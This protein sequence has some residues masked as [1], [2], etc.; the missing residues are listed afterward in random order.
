MNNE[1][2]AHLW[3]PDEEAH[4]LTKDLT[5]R[6]KQ[7]NISFKEHGSKLSRN[8]QQIKTDIDKLGRNNSLADSGIIVLGVELQEGE[9]V[10][11]KDDLFAS[12]G[13]KVNAVRDTRNA[14]VSITPSQYQKLNERIDAYSNNGTYRTSF[15]NVES[16]KPYTGQV[17]DSNAIKKNVAME[18][19]PVTIDIQL[20]L[21]P[22]LDREIYQNV[23]D[24][25]TQRTEEIQGKIESVYYLSD[26]TPVIRAII[27]SV[28]LSGYEDDPAVYRIEETS[29]FTIDA[30]PNETVDLTNLILNPEININ[31]LPIV[32]ILD[33]GVSFPSNFVSLIA[34]QW[35]PKL[36]SAGGGI[37]DSIHGTKV[38]GNAVFRYL[39][40]NIN[41][42]VITP[43][44]RI[45]DCNILTGS[46]PQDIFL[47]RIREAVITFENT[48]KIFN[49]SANANGVP[50]EG[51]KMSILG[52]E[53]DALQYKYGIQFVVSA[54]NHNLWQ[55]EDSLTNIINDDDTRISSP[56]DSMLSIVVGSVVGENHKDSLSQKDEIAPYSRR[57]P[58]FI[59]FSKPDISAYAGTLIFLQG[60][61]IVPKDDYSLVLSKK[62]VLEPD[63]GTSYSAP[64]IA[65][66]IAEISSFLPNNDILL[67]KALLYQEVTPLWDIDTTN[68]DEL[69]EWHNRYGRGISNLEYSKYSSTSRVTLLR[70]GTL[71]RRTKERVSIYM[72]PVL[73]A[74]KGRNTA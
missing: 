25:L 45:I 21:I 51:D 55:F 68:D 53:L 13:M 47:Q 43:R 20:M 69:S 16:F 12:N 26:D 33:S 54:G 23:I 73:A 8:L 36:S 30:D 72:P 71:N 64:I 27:P 7:R 10:Q 37:G 62:G 40:Q 70:T 60:K 34:S 58:G 52:Y 22:N 74:Q 18:K 59:G 4:K 63:A 44:A 66:D 67:A 38:A 56:A 6:P 65:G 48:A 15:E 50:I 57:G 1:Q 9:K 24:K 31:E 11:D 17:K 5:S 3:I 35:Q 46:V 42:N 19:P 2:L 41:G 29:F 49:L 14:I 39:K 61:K 28:V 32:A